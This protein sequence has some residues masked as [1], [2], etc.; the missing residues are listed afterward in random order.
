MNVYFIIILFSLTKILTAWQNL[1]WKIFKTWNKIF[2]L[3]RLHAQA[4]EQTTLYF[5]SP[6]YL[7]IIYIFIYHITNGNSGL[8]NLPEQWNFSSWRIYSI[9][10]NCGEMWEYIYYGLVIQSSHVWCTP[11]VS[12][13][14]TLFYIDS[15]RYISY[16]SISRRPAMYLAH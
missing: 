11:L 14:S 2:S 13:L 9:S 12:R 16:Q 4:T 5:S 10:F 3:Q 1:K 8:R 15:T 7:H 6:T